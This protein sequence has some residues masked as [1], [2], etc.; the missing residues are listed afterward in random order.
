MIARPKTAREIEL[1]RL[2]A[3]ERERADSAAQPTAPPPPAPEPGAILPPAAGHGEFHAWAARHGHPL[4]VDGRTYFPD[5]AMVAGMGVRHEPA[6]DRATLD[7][8]LAYWREMLAQ[9][10]RWHRRLR[11]HPNHY[12][13]EGFTWPVQLFG[14][15]PKETDRAGMQ[16]VRAALRR[17]Q[18]IAQ[19]ARQ[20]IAHVEAEVAAR[21]ARR[22][23]AMA[24]R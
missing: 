2:L 21:D 16:C 11:D 17:L 9:A 10:E 22:P 6:E 5:G 23:A 19:E 12:G 8:R 20:A 3:Q 24:G 14:P 7:R 15:A 18:S 13:T 4:T 1:E